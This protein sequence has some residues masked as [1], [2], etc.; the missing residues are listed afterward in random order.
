[1]KKVIDKIKREKIICIIVILLFIERIIVAFQLGITYNLESDDLSYVISGIEFANTGRITMHGVLSAQIM[2]GMPVLIGVMSFLFGEDYMLWVALKFLWFTMGSLTALFIYKSVKIFVPRWCAILATLPLFAVDFAWMD[3]TILTETPFM[4][5]FVIMIYATFMMGKERSAKYY[6]ICAVAYMLALMFKA[7][8]GVYPV[9][10]M[11]YLLIVKYDF[12]KLLKQG[13]ILGCLVLCF[14]IP[15]SVRN[16][17]HYDA[18]VPLTWGAGNPMLLGTYQGYGYPLDEELDYEMNV[19]A[20]AEK[21]FAKYYNENGELKKDY[22]VKYIALEK[23]GIMAKYRMKEWIKRDPVSMVLSYLW[24]K[25]M[26][27]IDSVFYWKEV[28]GIGVDKLYILRD[29]NLWL[30]II[31]TVAAFV[32]KKYREEIFFLWFLYLGNIYIYA[33]TFAFNRYAATLMPTRYIIMGIGAY[34]CVK[35]LSELIEWTRQYDI[36]SKA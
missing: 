17:I 26:M 35:L 24:F 15:W 23:D 19:E 4:F 10:A 6:I 33:M 1:M 7:N 8:I 27:M 32:L 2:P 9:F 29:I 21:E 13:I 22:L 28:L 20:V 16:Y 31:S 36:E 34:L 14:V 11:I 12:K 30:C 3:N 25:P 18:F 5:C